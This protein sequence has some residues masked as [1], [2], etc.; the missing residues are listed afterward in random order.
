MTISRDDYFKAYAGHPEIT[1]EIEAN[2]DDLLER[3]NALRAEAA[4][5]GVPMPTNPKTGTPISGDKNGGFRPQACPVGAP[6][7][8]HKQGNGVDNYDPHRS[9]ASWCM[10][11]LDRLAAHGLYMEDPR[12]TPTWTH[13]QRVAP[14]SGKVVFIPSTEPALAGNP[15][16]WGTA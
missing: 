12:W 1:P 5:D 16:A 10:A 7:S 14:R 3:V 4:A 15:P 11:H 6:A 9:L 8:P 2:A 13:L